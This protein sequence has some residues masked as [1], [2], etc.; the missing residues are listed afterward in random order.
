MILLLLIG[1]FHVL[2]ATVIWR[3]NLGLMSHLKD[4]RSLG[5][6][7]LSLVFM[8]GGLCTVTTTPPPTP[9]PGGGRGIA[10]EISGALTKVLPRQCGGNTRGLIYECTGLEIFLRTY[11]SC[12]ASCKQFSLVL[13]AGALVL[14]I[15]ISKETKIIKN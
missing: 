14:K 11:S 2:T 13:T 8:A 4:W 3:R 7:P 10:V 5:S 15:W 1:R 6:N 9:R 12:G